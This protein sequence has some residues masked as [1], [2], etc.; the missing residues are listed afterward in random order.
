MKAARGNILDEKPEKKP[1]AE[2]LFRKDCFPTRSFWSV[3]LQSG[4]EADLF[5]FM[6]CQGIIPIFWGA[7]QFAEDFEGRVISI[8]CT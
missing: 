8:L 1:F 6:S 5:I 7:M 2:G 3:K 4:L